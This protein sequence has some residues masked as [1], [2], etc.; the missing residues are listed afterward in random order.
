[1][2]P[3]LLTIPTEIR[4]KILDYTVSDVIVQ[5]LTPTAHSNSWVLGRFNNPN[6]AI[7]SV[8][9]QLRNES[10]SQR[11]LKPILTIDGGWCKTHYRYCVLK[12]VSIVG[13]MA[14]FS[15]LRFEDVMTYGPLWLGS[16]WSNN[17]IRLVVKTAMERHL[18]WYGC[19]V[20]VEKPEPNDTNYPAHKTTVSVVVKPH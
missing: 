3:N 8:C 12:D 13:R 4:I 7:G 16:L 10:K 11:V 2:M 1:M 9:T 17:D 5:E 19:D 18:G 14:Q 15:V 20:E 6:L